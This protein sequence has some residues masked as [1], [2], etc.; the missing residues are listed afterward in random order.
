LAGKE[1]MTAVVLAGGKSSRMGQNKMFLPLGGKPV[2]SH[3]L[4]VLKQIF[5]ECIVVTDEPALYQN[6]GVKVVQ[7]IIVCREKNSLTGIHAGLFCAKYPYAFMLAGDMPFVQ[8]RVLKY[9]CTFAAD[10]DVVVPK[11]GKFYQPLCAIYHKN[12]LPFIEEQL[13]NGIFRI[14][15]FFPKVRLCEVD[16]NEL[17]T[18]DPKGYTFFNINTPE[19]YA[20]A[21][22]IYQLIR[23]TQKFSG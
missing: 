16:V 22:E 1:K 7:D 13:V 20:R 3:L 23:P 4:E 17:K 18:F 9:L 10:C 19:D 2:I 5:T 11:E 15:R 21:C 14:D 6:Y 12:C 8:P